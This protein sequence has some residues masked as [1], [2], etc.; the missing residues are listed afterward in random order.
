MADYRP[1]TV[2]SCQVNRFQCFGERTNLI[3]LNQMALPA[4]CWMPFVSGWY[5]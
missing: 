2:A 1:E 3:E 5:W 4:A